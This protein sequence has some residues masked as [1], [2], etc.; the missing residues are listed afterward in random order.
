[1]FLIKDGKPMT[2]ELRELAENIA[3]VHVESYLAYKPIL[4]GL[5]NTVVSEKEFEFI[6]DRFV[7]F[8]GYEKNEELFNEVCSQYS[9]IYPEAVA[10]QRKQLQ[11]QFYE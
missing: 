11:E 5:M 9:T 7:G 2:K 1:M 3:N 8:C 4:E 10:F 6:M